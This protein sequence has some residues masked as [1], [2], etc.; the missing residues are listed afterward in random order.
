MPSGWGPVEVAQRRVVGDT[1]V[2]LVDE[3]DEGLGPPTSPCGPM[4][5]VRRSGPVFVLGH[6]PD[7]FHVEDLDGGSQGLDLAVDTPV[8][9]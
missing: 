9:R 8:W 5:V 2:E 4:P 6:R 7:L 3:K 1:D